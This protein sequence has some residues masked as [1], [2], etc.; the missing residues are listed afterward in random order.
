VKTSA[1]PLIFGEVLFDRFPD[2]SE[3]LGGAPFNVAWNLQGLGL[4][5]LLISAVG[6]DDLGR[7]VLAAMD[8]WGMARNGVQVDSLHETGIVNVS[9]RDGEPSFEIVADRAWD[10]IER[11]LLPDLP[12]VG[13]VY[14]GTLA[15]RQQA[16]RGA[17]ADLLRRVRAPAFVDVNLRAPWWDRETVLS[18]LKAV[19]TIKM[20]ETELLDLAPGGG[21]LE[22]GAKILLERYRPELLCVTRG[23]DGAVAYTPA[24]TLRVAPPGKRAVV[25]TVGAGD[26]FAAAMIAGILCGWPMET[27]LVRAQSL[28]GE[29]VG[30]KGA[31][32]A[33]I[34][35]YRR[36]RTEWKI[37]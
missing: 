24:R 36:I 21:T 13:L 2:G 3:V 23:E 7:R 19:Q 5:P 6:D 26:A 14:H 37:A 30:L 32:T 15:S 8:S 33:D 34:D 29:V 11:D 18:S 20:N 25:D 10:K 22:A 9:L 1:R 31:V 16:S 35:F 27:T 4:D 28:A 17:L 12:Q